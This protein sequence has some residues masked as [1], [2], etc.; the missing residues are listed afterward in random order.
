MASCPGRPGVPAVHSVAPCWE[1]SRPPT[2]A[3]HSASG[4]LQ[5]DL[6]LWKGTSAS[7]RVRGSPW[8]SG[9]KTMNSRKALQW[10][11]T[12]PLV[13]QRDLTARLPLPPSPPH[14]GRSLGPQEALT[15]R[16]SPRCAGGRHTDKRPL[17]S[18]SR[19]FSHG[20]P[21]EN[22]GRQG[23][24]DHSFDGDALTVRTHACPSRLAQAEPVTDP[25]LQSRGRAC[26]APREVPPRTQQGQSRSGLSCPEEST[27]S[28]HNGLSFKRDSQVASAGPGLRATR[29]LPL[30]FGAR[31][32]WRP[33]EQE[34]PPAQGWGVASVERRGADWSPGL[35][36]CRVWDSFP[37]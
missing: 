26:G 20:A 13:T 15:S 6:A 22:P 4:A 25:V 19:A 28:D 14:P 17:F 5:T 27:N 2:W 37:L 1:R 31:G 23:D 35:R 16:A 32:L 29:S 24:S 9:R 8:L 33:N 11:H 3:S 21:P 30:S 18:C 10:G 7:P 36:F 34:D 12:G